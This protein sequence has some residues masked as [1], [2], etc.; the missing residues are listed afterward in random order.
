MAFGFL[1][2]PVII[3]HTRA[4]N[5]LQGMFK[6]KEIEN[7]MAQHRGDLSSVSKMKIDAALEKTKQTFLFLYAH[8]S[9]Y[10]IRIYIYTIL[11]AFMYN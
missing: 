2:R 10:R 9:V 8:M 6:I 7:S 5:W 3:G 4:A 11:H 1:L